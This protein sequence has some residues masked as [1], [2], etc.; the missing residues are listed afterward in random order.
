M[1]FSTSPKR[2][3]INEVSVRDGF[4]SEPQFVPTEQKIGLIDRLS[5]T[6]L[7]RIEVTSFV[8]PNA[9]PN[10]RDAREVM[11]GIRRKPGVVYAALV[12]NE[13]GCERALEC[14]MDE[15]NLV[16]S[17]GETHNLANMRMTHEQSLEQ[18]RRVM[19]LARGTTLQVNGCVAT[20]F[21]CPFEGDQP[22]AKVMDV[23]RRYLDMGMNSITL[24]DT[25]GMAD[26][27]QV[28]ELCRGFFESFP[29]VPLTAHFH[30]TRGMGLA[31]VIAALD[32]GVSS[33]DASLGG[34]G[35]CPYAPGATGNI[36]TEDLVHMLA[37]C[38]VD[39]GVDLDR[40]L[41][42]AKALPS[43][44]GHEVPGQVMRA[45]KTTDLHPSPISPQ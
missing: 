8:S 1:L 44:V 43:I 5:E 38:G 19:N 37:S 39:T 17:A 15:I 28:S 40:L 29:G 21:G 45:G 23:V 24:A 9:I 36:C 14:R 7:A 2:V 31:N 4:Q 34:I 42:I 20:A 30:N 41:A 27:R 33:F 32:A 25:T 11:S 10:L 3:F 16:M 12:P 22:V 26:P 18:F 13:R 6:G 35:G